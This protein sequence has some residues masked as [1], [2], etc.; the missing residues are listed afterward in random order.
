MILYLDKISFAW[1]FIRVNDNNNISWVIIW[2][3]NFFNNNFDV[4]I[5]DNILLS[6]SWE[7]LKCF[8]LFNNSNIFNFKLS[9]FEV[10]ALSISLM[11]FSESSS[12]MYNIWKDVAFVSYFLAKLNAELNIVF[13]LSENSLVKLSILKTYF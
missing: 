6:I 5:K 13:D 10:K 2:S 8:F 1:S 7:I 11:Y 3:S 4:F 12:I 9:I